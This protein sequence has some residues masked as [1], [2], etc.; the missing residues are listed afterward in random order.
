M[1]VQIVIC[2]ASLLLACSKGKTNEYS[3]PDISQQVSFYENNGTLSDIPRCDRAT[4]YTHAAAVGISANVSSL[5]YPAGHLNRDSSP[6]YPTD[7]ATEAS[8][9]MYV[10]WLQAIWTDKDGQSLDRLISYGNANNW[11]MG[12][13]NKSINDISVLV[14]II[15]IMQEKLKTPLEVTTT[16]PDID[17]TLSGFQG[18]ILASYLWLWFRVNGDMG[19]V[20]HEAINALYG[21]NNSDPMYSAL[22]HRATDGN[23]SE[24]YAQLN[25][26]TI[27]PP[28]TI[29]HTTGSFN[30]GS[31]PDWLYYLLVNGIITGV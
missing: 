9:E 1:K 29:T 6:C 23:Y 17:E 4:F 5:E 8:R 21:S 19:P 28:N 22:Q 31:C 16:V 25:S 7:S 11:I 27:F 13:G 26:A 2:L 12:E 14:P 20:G 24:T 3:P 30:W 15:L 10:G 18:H